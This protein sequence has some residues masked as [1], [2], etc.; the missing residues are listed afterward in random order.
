MFLIPFSLL[1]AEVDVEGG[2]VAAFVGP[3]GRGQVQDQRQRGVRHLNYYHL[4]H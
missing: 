3:V 4:H 1:L 2:Q